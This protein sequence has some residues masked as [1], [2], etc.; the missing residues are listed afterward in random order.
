MASPCLALDPRE[1]A[2]ECCAQAHMVLG[3][4]V[5]LGILVCVFPDDVQGRH[6]VRACRVELTDLCL[7]CSFRS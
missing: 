5:V 4:F 2:Y 1:V 3:H 7:V 6:I